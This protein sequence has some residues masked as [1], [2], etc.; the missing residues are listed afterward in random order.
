M[1]EIELF[2]L[3]G[4]VLVAVSLMMA[5]LKKL[6]WINLT[7]ATVFTIYGFL[8]NAL[9]VYLLNGWIM[10]VNVWYLRAMYKSREKFDLITPI[11]G[12]SDPVVKMFLHEY[13]SDIKKIFAHFDQEKSAGSSVWLTYRDLKP[14]GI[15]IFRPDEQEN[16]TYIELDY[17]APEYR[18]MKNAKLIFERQLKKLHE[19]GS[20]SLVT[21]GE[22]PIHQKYLDSLGFSATGAGDLYRLELAAK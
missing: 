9:P 14:S 2:G 4:S 7:G 18:D 19:K 22:L 1:S 6:R 8:I 15:F 13:D 12:I 21:K 17:V 10:F 5:N 3:F 11:S 20:H 16:T